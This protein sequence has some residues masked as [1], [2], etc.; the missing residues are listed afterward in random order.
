[1]CFSPKIKTPTIEPRAPDPEPLKE[2][3]SG[4]TFGGMDESNKDSS[5]VSG[6][7]GLKV[8]RDD[9]V[10]QPDMSKTKRAIR[11]TAFGI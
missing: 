2:E 6:R 11:K 7:K 5:E 8:E 4:V 10:S 3:V 9:S 1:M